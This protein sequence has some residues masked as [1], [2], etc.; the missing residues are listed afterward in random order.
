MFSKKISFNDMNN[1]E[2]MTR[3]WKEYEKLKT[4]DSLK[5]ASDYFQRIH[6]RS[7]KQLKYEYI[8]D[9]LLEGVKD[10]EL[11]SRYG[12]VTL[13]KLCKEERLSEPL[14][15]AIYF[16]I[17]TN[18]VIAKIIQQGCIPNIIVPVKKSSNISVP[19][20]MKHL[21]S[22]FPKKYT[23][24][25]IIA[26]FSF[27][28]DISAEDVLSF[29]QLEISKYDLEEL[30]LF[31]YCWVLLSL[32]HLISKH[33]SLTMFK[34][35]FNLVSKSLNSNQESFIII[36]N[37]AVYPRIYFFNEW[38]S[39]SITIL[40]HCISKLE[41]CHNVITQLVDQFVD[42][43]SD[44][45]KFTFMC[46][47]E[48][49]TFRALPPT[50]FLQ[51]NADLMLVNL[52][53][54]VSI[55]DKCIDLLLDGDL[56]IEGSNSPSSA[57]SEDIRAFYLLFISK[58][59]RSYSVKYPQLS[60]NYSTLLLRNHEKLRNQFQDCL[61]AQ[62]WDKFI[63][64]NCHLYSDCFDALYWF[65]I[66]NVMI[67]SE[68]LKDHSLIDILFNNIKDKEFQPLIT[69]YISNVTK[70]T[71]YSKDSTKVLQYF[72]ISDVDYFISVL[73]KS[74]NSNTLV[75]LMDVFTDILSVCDDLSNK[76]SIQSMIIHYNLLNIFYSNLN[77]HHGIKF[78]TFYKQLIHKSTLYITDSI[79]YNDI[80]NYFKSIKLGPEDLND[81]CDLLLCELTMPAITYVSVPLLTD[82][83]SRCTSHQV[84]ETLLG[85]LNQFVNLHLPLLAINHVNFYDLFEHI[86]SKSELTIWRLLHESLASH[87][88]NSLLFNKSHLLLKNCNTSDKLSTWLLFHTNLVSIHNKTELICFEPIKF[89]SVPFMDAVGLTIYM[90]YKIVKNDATLNITHLD[91]NISMIHSVG[92]KVN[93]IISFKNNKIFNKCIHTDAQP[94]TNNKILITLT[95]HKNSLRIYFIINGIPHD[96]EIGLGVIVIP[97][98]V[99]SVNKLHLFELST[100]YNLPISLINQFN[101]PLVLKEYNTN[102][103]ISIGFIFNPIIN[104]DPLL[105]DFNSYYSSN[106]NVI[107]VPNNAIVHS[108]SYSSNLTFDLIAQP[109]ALNIMDL[110]VLNQYVTYVLSIL[111]ENNA[112]ANTATNSGSSVSLSN[113]LLSSAISMLNN[114][115]MLNYKTMAPSTVDVLFQF[116]INGLNKLIFNVDLW[117]LVDAPTFASYQDHV[118]HLNTSNLLMDCL[119]G[120]KMNTLYLTIC[121]SI[122]YT[123]INDL[124]P[125]ACVYIKQL[126][127]SIISKIIDALIPSNMLLD[128]LNHGSIIILLKSLM[129]DYTVVQSIC[130]FI[131]KYYKWSSPLLVF[132]AKTVAAV[133][134][135][136]CIKK[137]E[138]ILNISDLK[139]Y[140]NVHDYYLLLHAC[141]NSTMEIQNINTIISKMPTHYSFIVEYMGLES[142]GMP[143]VILHSKYKEIQEL[144]V[145][146]INHILNVGNMQMV[147]KY[148][149]GFVYNGNNTLLYVNNAYIMNTVSEMYLNKEINVNQLHDHYKMIWGLWTLNYNSSNGI[150]GN[151]ARVV[152][153]TRFGSTSSISLYTNNTD[154]ITNPWKYNI[155]I[156]EKVISKCHL[157]LDLQVNE[158]II[159]YYFNLIIMGIYMNNSSC[160]GSFMS[161]FNRIWSDKVLLNKV[162]NKYYIGIVTEESLIVICIVLYPYYK[163]NE[164]TRSLGEIIKY[165]TRKYPNNPLFDVGDVELDVVASKLIETDEINEILKEMDEH[166][167]YNRLQS[168]KG[169]QEYLQVGEKATEEDDATSYTSTNASV[170][171]LAETTPAAVPPAPLSTPI[172]SIISNI[173]TFNSIMN[174][175]TDKVQYTIDNHVNLEG[176]QRKLVPCT[177]KSSTNCVLNDLLKHNVYTE[178]LNVLN[179]WS[180]NQI[181]KVYSLQVLVNDVKCTMVL[182]QDMITTS[183]SS[184]TAVYFVSEISN[185]FNNLVLFDGGTYMM[186]V[187]NNKDDKMIFNKHVIQY[188]ID[189]LDIELLTMKRDDY[190]S[191][192]TTEYKHGGIT[193]TMYTN[194]LKFIH[195]KSEA[196]S[197]TNDIYS[198]KMHRHWIEMEPK[199]DIAHLLE[200][201]SCDIQHGKEW[202]LNT[203]CGVYS[204]AQ[205]KISKVNITGIVDMI[206][207]SKRGYY[208]SINILGIM[209]YQQD[210]MLVSPIITEGYSNMHKGL[211]EPSVVCKSE[212][213]RWI[214][215]GYKDG[216]IIK[217]RINKLTGMIRSNSRIMG[218]VFCIDVM[219]T[220]SDNDILCSCSKD[221][222]LIHG[223]NSGTLIKRLKISGTI[224]SIIITPIKGDLILLNTTNKLKYIQH[225]DVNGELKS[226]SQT[227]VEKIKSG[228]MGHFLGLEEDSL[229][230]FDVNNMQIT[231]KIYVENLLDYSFINGE[232]MVITK[233]KLIKY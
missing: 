183:S 25:A 233:D 105:I 13:D 157:V 192:I 117:Q 207:H 49:S 3:L 152:Y 43:S 155:D 185:I 7:L 54:D 84:I 143:F 204:V 141:M 8:P 205:N 27:S 24:L 33:E 97:F 193:G 29:K 124:L 218:H 197:F 50:S 123:N 130:S 163:Y 44:A 60:I 227:T 46:M 83:I 131:V 135:T 95:R 41:Y 199:V 94:L 150:T 195:K 110:G 125:M 215:V 176:I 144:H 23:L 154:V 224:N 166:D 82:L 34:N 100:F 210:G 89:P 35:F 190:Y 36:K 220:Q 170:P 145:K 189:V 11:L 203:N 120:L 134:N 173:N 96:E 57:S 115:L 221:M 213:D 209:I 138:L 63:F 19:F 91:F 92:G 15:K 104:T 175:N 6:V 174:M 48:L 187:F 64:K 80:F 146:W 10:L 116:S 56:S 20:L 153:N 140:Y 212:D 108:S 229:I 102:S 165:V 72:N 103:L 107:R 149:S 169:I 109:L 112:I 14:T 101:M 147:Y 9:K 158:S 200:V 201:T 79:N 12:K 66:D 76:Q 37:C 142:W 52:S 55:R 70:S 177:S 98:I 181:D 132:D 71:V 59:M 17:D 137:P 87:T 51:S 61:I 47:H 31:L 231:R 73:I 179:E 75:L 67:I 161:L 156:L 90:N 194:R 178:E 77:S 159:F 160:R 162:I 206:V 126:P 68:I 129:S 230:V 133:K 16:S 217:H 171:V 45:M 122:I 4:E 114:L 85:K 167:K 136:I 198:S 78:L 18:L 88:F 225:Y 69:L 232:M 191:H 184:A 42:A 2:E 53:S 22:D 202:I 1:H 128:I 164:Y 226:T 216:Q 211:H 99:I 40:S 106:V 118:I 119:N 38:T 58:F 196:N 139:E 172:S 180:I 93:M 222:V 39:K 86:H 21:G 121:I 65:C 113:G 214:V 74:T 151:E 32:R 182:N 188:G 26:S 28:S 5:K 30:C 168:V 81:I 127:S 111:N 62:E 186:I 148:M 223:L 228:D 208:Y 219:Q